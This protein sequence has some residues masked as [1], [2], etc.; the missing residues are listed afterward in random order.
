MLNIMATDKKNLITKEGRESLQKEFDELK[1]VKMPKV[2]ERVSTARE[3]GDL[4]ENSEYQS[5]KEEQEYL[6]MRLGELEETLK[7]SHVIGPGTVKGKGIVNI[8]SIVTVKDDEGEVEYTIVGT[9]EADPLNGRIS[10]ESPVGAALVGKKVGD[11]V[12]VQSAGINTSYT[13][14]KVR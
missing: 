1:N 8:G 12:I 11:T 7:N 10:V 6:E 4:S 5:A 2:I 13:I 14:V 3:A 9:S